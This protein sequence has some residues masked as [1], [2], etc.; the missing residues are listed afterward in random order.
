MGISKFNVTLDNGFVKES[1]TT[2]L[3]HHAKAILENLLSVTKGDLAQTAKLLDAI[4]NETQT[5]I[6]KLTEEENISDSEFYEKLSQ[7][8]KNHKE[9]LEIVEHL[10]LGSETLVE[11][12]D[13]QKEGVT[14]NPEKPNVNISNDQRRASENDDPS[15]YL[16]LTIGNMERGAAKN[17]ISEFRLYSPL[18]YSDPIRPNVRSIS[19]EKANE[20]MNG[21]DVLF[22]GSASSEWRH[23]VTIPK[24]FNMT[25]REELKK[26][27]A[28]ASCTSCRLQDGK[29]KI[30]HHIRE[31]ECGGTGQFRAQPIPANVYLPRYEQITEEN[32]RRRE[33]VKAYSQEILKQT[34]KPFRFT[35]REKFRNDRS[36][37]ASEVMKVD[38]ARNQLRCQSARKPERERSRTAE[39]KV[40]EHVSQG[41]SS[42]MEDDKLLREIKRHLRAER[43]LQSAA[44]PPGMEE[45]QIRSQLRRAERMARAQERGLPMSETDQRKPFKA[46]PAPDFKKVHWESE[47]ALR[48]IWQPPPDP[49]CP[50]PFKLRTTERRSSS[51][52]RH[53]TQ[54]SEPGAYSVPGDSFCVKKEDPF[55][56]KRTSSESRY[57]QHA[58]DMPLPAKSHGTMLR[59]NHIRQSIEKMRFQTEKEKEAEL[60]TRTRQKEISRAISESLDDRVLQPRKVIDAM[61]EQRKQT[62]IHQD[63]DYQ[64][65]MEEMRKR[66]ASKP[67]LITRQ[68]QEVA[69]K[70]AEA[71]F[72]SALRRAGIDPQDI[73]DTF[74]DKPS[75][76]GVSAHHQNYEELYRREN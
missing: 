6:K 46:R 66:V 34:E 67:L 7:L 5:K 44:L 68:S 8:K 26:Q 72:N 54:Y 38:K 24:P 37:S 40:R 71:K 30:E 23:H 2:N 31:G 28:C 27:E 63:A 41:R 65:E 9:T 12:T 74:C 43:L 55:I 69:R 25:K 16:P 1:E 36:A 14:N 13:K 22:C 61:T 21:G 58:Y 48:R 59:E 56:R 15:S 20:C 73:T 60:A 10:Y 19:A 47:K 39:P 4:L 33:T 50:K 52:G 75:S 35:L 64:R 76:F 29:Q 32:A 57:L 49:T 3:S 70:R 17:P 62:L 45:R 53:T 51:S 18:K 11:K 42:K